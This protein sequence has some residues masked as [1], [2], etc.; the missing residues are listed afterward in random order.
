MTVFEARAE[1]GGRMRSDDLD[2][3]IVDPAVQLL[4][5]TFSSTIG[6]ARSVGLEQAIVR[7]PGRDA[8]WRRGRPH[9]VVYGSVSSLATSSALPMGLKLRMAARYLPWLTS[10]MRGLDANDPAR[11]GGDRWDDMSIAEWGREELGNDFVE[12]MVY[13]L[14]AAYYG[15][16]PERTS[17]PWYHALAR[18]GMDV[19]VLAIRGGMG[20]LPAAV[21]SSLQQHGGQL[22]TGISVRRIEPTNGGV[23][24]EHDAGTEEFEGAVVATPAAVAKELIDS[25]EANAWLE[26]VRATPTATLALRLDRPVGVDWFGLSFPPGEGPGRSLAGLCVQEQ[27]APGLVPKGAGLLV[28]LPSPALAPRMAEAE[29]QAVADALL[30]AIEQVFPKLGDR[31][32]R[33][34]AYRFTEGYTEFGPGH[35][36]HIRAFQDAWLPRNIALAG[37]YLVAPTVEGA[38]RSGERAAA[39]LMKRLGD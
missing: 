23:R 26:N 2:G 3:V 34:K 22:L 29:P 31:V 21:A 14:L 10:R 35:L 36:R 24:V 16:P 11:T 25:P 37:D 8:L 4:S 9:E 38:M 30:P 6:L 18:V 12:L 19:R 28:A 5:S 17:A 7:S 13:P 39:H 32:V 27:K 33:A 15:T 20:A 1:P